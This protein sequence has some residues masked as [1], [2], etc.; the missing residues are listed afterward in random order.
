MCIV[1]LPNYPTIA[2]DEK[3]GTRYISFGTII[4]IH[5]CHLINVFFFRTASFAILTVHYS[6]ADE[7]EDGAG[8]TYYILFPVSACIMVSCVYAYLQI[9]IT[10]YLLTQF[11]EDLEIGGTVLIA[12]SVGIAIGSVLSGV[13][14]Q[15]GVVSSYTQMAVGS[16]MVGTGLL[17][18]FPSPRQKWFYNNVPYIAYPAVVLS[19][20]GDPVMAVPTLVAMTDLQTLVTGRCTGQH[21]LSIFGIWLISTTC[22]NYMG[23][24]VGGA[25]MEFLTYEYA[26]Y[27]LVSVCAGGL[28]ISVG[29]RNFIIRYERDY[30][31]LGKGTKYRELYTSDDQLSS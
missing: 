11:D 2:L 30:L 26:A 27:L 14:T 25:L 18:M 7:D 23:A 3:E 10:P 15:S 8:L 20:M 28:V 13:V 22:A 6:D 31:T 4:I 9:S 12:L 21:S 17:L 19:G 24:L 5:T 29:M 16:G 1:Y